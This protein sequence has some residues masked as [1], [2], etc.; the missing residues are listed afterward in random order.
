MPDLDLVPTTILPRCPNCG[1][2][3][4]QINFTATIRAEASLM[5]DPDAATIHA[6]L[7]GRHHLPELDETTLDEHQPLTCAACLVRLERPDDYEID[8]TN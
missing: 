1:G 2:E 7:H 6:E 3:D 5:I 4:F 8:L